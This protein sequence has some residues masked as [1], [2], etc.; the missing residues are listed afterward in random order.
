MILK[1]KLV[2]VDQLLNTWTIRFSIFHVPVCIQKFLRFFS[3]LSNDLYH[4][5]SNKNDLIFLVAVNQINFP[6]N[7]FR[8]QIEIKYSMYEGLE[9]KIIWKKYG[10][11]Y[12]WKLIKCWDWHH[13]CCVWNTISFETYRFN[14]IKSHLLVSLCGCDII[15]VFWFI[16]IVT[17]KW[18]S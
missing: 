13:L 14:Q 4:H 16:G 17:I 8:T 3:F 11:N 18:I 15:M 6:I 7:R 9:T 2:S 10:K 12:N 5:R 1:K